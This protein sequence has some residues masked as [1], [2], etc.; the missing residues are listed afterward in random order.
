M[1]SSYLADLK[2]MTVGVAE[3]AP[4]FVLPLVRWSHKLG[5][6]LEENFVS[7]LAIADP[8]RPGF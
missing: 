8:D 3:E 2:E 5:S 4:R 1:R 6:A 7:L